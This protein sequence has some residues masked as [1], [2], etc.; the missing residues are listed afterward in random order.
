[1][2]TNGAAKLELIRS[3]EDAGTSS[4]RF[5]SFIHEVH[6]RYTIKKKQTCQTTIINH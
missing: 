1:M 4:F 5:A 2:Q 6:P 3:V